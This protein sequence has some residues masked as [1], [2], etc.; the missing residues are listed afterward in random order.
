[1]A[2]LLECHLVDQRADLKAESLV[3][4]WA[5]YLAGKKVDWMAAWRECLLAGQ[6]AALKAVP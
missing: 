4:H 6:M 2:V 5:A 3:G 1:M